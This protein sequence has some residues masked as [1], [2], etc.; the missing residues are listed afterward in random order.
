MTLHLIEG[1]AGCAFACDNRCVAVIV[2]ALRASATAAMLLDAGATEIH[3]VREVAEALELRDQLSDALL[4]GERGGLPLDGF[5]YGNSPRDVAIAAGRTIVFTTTTGSMRLVDAFGAAALYMGS[6]TNATAVLRA[7]ARHGTD[8]VLIP[9]GLAGDPE[10]DAQEDWTAAAAI[11]MLSDASVGEGALLYRDWRQK[12][13]LDGLG[14]LFDAAPH[15]EKLRAVGCEA[16][17]AFCARMD[18]TRAVPEAVSR[19][20]FGV[21]VRKCEA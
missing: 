8:V 15:A 16:D 9:A 20:E 4:F 5:D 12:I 13:E 1:E 7:A 2:D 17:I 14:A 11:A 10:F 6:T 18:V 19:T 21:L 3:I